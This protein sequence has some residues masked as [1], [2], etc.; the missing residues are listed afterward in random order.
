M[1]GSG[2]GSDQPAP[3]AAA[4]PPDD[5]Q[6]KAPAA[7]ERQIDLG[8]MFAH[9]IASEQSR[10][11]FE[12][13]TAAFAMG[14]LLVEQG[15]LDAAAYAKRR[16]TIG[17]ALTDQVKR[18]GLGLMLRDGDDDKYHLPVAT[19]Q[20]D[21]RARIHACKG[22]CCALRFALSRQDVEEGVV[23]WDLGRP[24]LIRQGADGYCVHS[25]PSSRACGVYAQR[26]APCRVYDCRNDDR[27][28][29]DF[30]KMIPRPGL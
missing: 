25:D 1:T 7:L 2:G 26:P 24:Y 9:S 4:R 13:A 15:L 12:V 5:D 8:F 20:I 30:D 18:S 17:A 11:L 14:E 16:E 10:Q 3:S 27:I 6:P 19:P 23:R 28:W 22:A 21:C 29:L